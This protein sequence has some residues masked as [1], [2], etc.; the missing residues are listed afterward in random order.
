MKKI[1]TIILMSSIFVSCGT[2]SLKIQNK[3]KKVYKIFEG[4]VLDQ[5]E[6]ASMISEYTKNS[7][8]A[9]NP[10]AAD[11]AI[12]FLEEN[13][14][15]SLLYNNAQ[16]SKEYERFE[17]EYFRL[18]DLPISRKFD[19]LKIKNIDEQNFTDYI[20]KFNTVENAAKRL[21]LIEK[22]VRNDFPSSHNSDFFSKLLL[23][24]S[25]VEGKKQKI[26]LYRAIKSNFKHITLQ[27]NLY[28]FQKVPIAA[29]EELVK[30]Q[31]GEGYKKG[32][33]FIEQYQLKTNIEYLRL[34]EKKLQ[35][36]GIENV[37]FGALL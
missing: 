8:K 20:A 29:L 37:D 27:L 11:V 10:K 23:M 32:R 36:A 2:S 26:T 14:Y 31:E 25:K 5:N 7:G 34:L 13:N 28:V 4:V 24:I 33:V 6:L 17:E 1:L 3:D 15:S 9:S 19:L 35:D 30:V 16:A 12:E 21:D 22:I 18:V